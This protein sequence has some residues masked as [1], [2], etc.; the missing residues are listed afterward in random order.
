MRLWN[1]A[2]EAGDQLSDHWQLKDFESGIYDLQLY[3]PNGFYRRFQGDASDPLIEVKCL[4]L[5]TQGN[6]KATGEVA[7]KISNLGT[8]QYTIAIVDQTYKNIDKTIRLGAVGTAKAIQTVI[9][10]TA[11]SFAWYDVI[12]KELSRPAFLKQF[13]GHVETGKFSSTD[14]AMA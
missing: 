8:E 12:L 13:A 5:S 10:P 2:L 6:K 3:G 14:P 7:I 1:Y 11:R 4:Y 9:V